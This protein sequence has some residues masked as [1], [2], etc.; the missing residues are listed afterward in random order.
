MLRAV[1]ISRYTLCEFPA[2]TLIVPDRL[3]KHRS[4]LD[5]LTGFFK[6]PLGQPKRYARIEAALRVEGV[7]Q[8]AK[9]VVANHE[10]LQR[11]FAVV[12]LDLV[13]VLAAHGVVGS[14]HLQHPR[15]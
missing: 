1:S 3:S 5:I 12:E 15:G 4:V 10:I 7:Q 6:R 13:E 8:L 2:R 11:Q 14:G 9:P